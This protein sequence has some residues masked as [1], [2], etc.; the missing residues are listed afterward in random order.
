M[1]FDFT[2][3]RIYIKPGATDFRTSREELLHMIKDVMKKDPF[4]GAVF[5]FCNKNRKLLKMIFWDRNGFWTAS[6][7]LEKGSWPW[8]DT[9]DGTRELNM[10]QIR[11]LLKG[12]DFFHQHKP[13]DFKNID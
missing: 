4:S 5:I 6:K 11:M 10:A 7:V 13:L 8:P 2:N 9:A 3:T 1:R 12:I